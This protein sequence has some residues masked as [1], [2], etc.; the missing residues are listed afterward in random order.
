MRTLAT[1]SQKGGVGKTTL[2]LNLA[3]AFA[4]RGLRTVLV[5]T[6]PQGAVGLSLAGKKS[7]QAGLA[8]WLAGTPLSDALIQTKLPEL[9]LITVGTPPIDGLQRWLDDL[10]TGEALTRLIA[11]LRERGFDLVMV[12]TPAGVGGATQGAL[13]ACAD[14]VVPLQSEPL[15]LRTLPQT[16]RA[17]NAM[18]EQGSDLRLA[19]I[20][21]TMTRFREQTT[22][23]VTQEAWGT[24]PTELLVDT[25][26]P[27]DEVFLEASAKGVPVG[28]LRRRPPPV[29]GVFDNL[30]A[31]LE[32]RIGL[33]HEEEDDAPIHLLD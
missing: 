27:R 1:V 19:A 25:H 26:I 13:R 12:D 8:E 9:A 17:I 20:V 14:V 24:L 18:R 21:L 10:S 22:F 3:F 31:E 23:A 4:K 29:A 5:D 7:R 6:D 28:L 15:A 30:A 32:A 2:A 11:Q 16:L 33:A